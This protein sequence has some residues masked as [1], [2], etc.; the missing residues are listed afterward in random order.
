MLCNLLWCLYQGKY[1]VCHFSIVGVF[2][3]QTCTRANFEG[4][5][6]FT[7]KFKALSF[8]DCVFLVD[9][10]EP[11]IGVMPENGGSENVLGDFTF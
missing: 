10:E 6:D 2:Y 1:F 11:Q 8:Q 3:N 7:S 9:T 5:P 4:C